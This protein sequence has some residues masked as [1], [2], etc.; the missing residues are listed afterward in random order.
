MLLHIRLFGE[1]G[2]SAELYA[3]IDEYY[4]TTSAV[5]DVNSLLL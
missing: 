3:C 5:D 4:Q 1:T 2:Q